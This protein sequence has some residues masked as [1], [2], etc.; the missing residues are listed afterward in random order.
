MI[1]V[2]NLNLDPES[3]DRDFQQLPS[4]E[5]IIGLLSSGLEE[6]QKQQAKDEGSALQIKSAF[7]QKLLSAIK[8]EKP[9]KIDAKENEL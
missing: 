8:K 4:P 3:L 9:N 6:A 2:A 7:K 5:K 1:Y